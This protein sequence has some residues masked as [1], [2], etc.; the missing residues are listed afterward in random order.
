MR[1]GANEVWGKPLPDTEIL[2]ADINKARCLLLGKLSC[3]LPCSVK[4]AIIDDSTASAK[5][6]M[7]RIQL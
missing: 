6:L 1:A 5:L 2:I 7:R 3:Q 4:V